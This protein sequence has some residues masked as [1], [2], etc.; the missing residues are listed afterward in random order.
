MNP[1]QGVPEERESPTI[2]IQ[3]N[4][5]FGGWRELPQRRR[6]VAYFGFVALLAL[7]FIRPLIAL[8]LYSAET[9]LHSHILL[10]PSISAYLIYIRRKQLPVD[11]GSSP[12]WIVLLLAAG[13]A[14]L[15][16]GGA[17]FSPPSSQNDSLSLMALSFVCF[18]A[19]GGFVFLGR[20]WMTA[21]AFPFAFLVFMVP[22]PDS[23]ANLLETALKLASA[24]AA[25]LLFDTVSMPVWRDGTVFQLPGITI[26]VAQQC[27]GIRSSWA[28]FITSMLASYL[29]LKTPW[30]RVGLV[31]IVFPLAVVRNGFRIM[32]IG[33]LCMEF[34]PQMINSFV[35]H[36]GGPLFFALSLAPLFLLLWWLRSGEAGTKL[37]VSR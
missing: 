16:A 24:E 14:T 27:S 5:F 17:F 1:V 25:A 18:L 30:R 4:R 34:G 20:R 22:L 9:D 31:A 37:R 12:G 21:A 28:L 6:L 35:H 2:A 26:E 23:I 29:F 32:V 11:Y 10:I 13:I 36:H 8:A 3:Q 7:A 19:A 15:A 33:W